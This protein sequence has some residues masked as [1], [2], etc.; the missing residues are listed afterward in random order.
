VWVHGVKKVVR[1]WG[2]VKGGAES[3]EGFLGWESQM[4]LVAEVRDVES[5]DPAPTRR[6][7]YPRGWGSS[8]TADPQA[9]G[10][11]AGDRRQF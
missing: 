1:G 11:Q 10:D 6:R 8:L 3:Q 5:H 2:K 9:N 4:E 7:A